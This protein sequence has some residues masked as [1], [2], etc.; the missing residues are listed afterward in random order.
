[1][2][3]VFIRIW[4]KFISQKSIKGQVI[5]DHLAKAPLPNDNPLIIELPNEHVFQLDNIDSSTELVGQLTWV[6]L[7]DTIIESVD[8]RKSN[9]VD[10]F[11]CFHS[12]LVSH[13]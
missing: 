6:E 1:M 9:D 7:V 8:S 5:A 2:D 12:V 11:L 10:L 13:C 3:H 4:L